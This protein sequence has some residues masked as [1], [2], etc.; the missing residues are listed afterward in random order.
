MAPKCFSFHYKL[1][2]KYKMRYGNN[3]I[4]SGDCYCVRKWSSE[5]AGDPKHWFSCWLS[6]L[7]QEQIDDT[8]LELKSKIE[9]ENRNNSTTPHK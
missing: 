9:K 1:V 5:F 3:Q 8:I 4:F 7:K 2:H 6:L